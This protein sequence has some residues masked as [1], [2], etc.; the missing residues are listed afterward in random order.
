MSK[1]SNAQSE[2]IDLKEI[3]AA[4]WAHK[5]LIFLVT[6]L[7]VFFSVY[8]ILNTSKKFTARAIFQ[9]QEQNKSGISFGR[10]GL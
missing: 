8:H 10:F 6:S 2:E 1:N 9:I 4:L 7:F 3:L 5:I